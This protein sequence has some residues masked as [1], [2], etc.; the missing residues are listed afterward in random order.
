MKVRESQAIPIFAG[1]CMT[2]RFHSS[3]MPTRVLL[4]LF[5]FLLVVSATAATATTTPVVTL[6]DT[7]S[8]AANVAGGP[9]SAGDARTLQ[10][11]T[12]GPITESAAKTFDT[13]TL[14]ANF[15]NSALPRGFYA[16]AAT[17]I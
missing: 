2:P 13:V 7:L 4:V 10:N 9:T 12:F 16:V 1:D 14:A 6:S 11:A 17:P 5:L 8:S 3:P 15:N